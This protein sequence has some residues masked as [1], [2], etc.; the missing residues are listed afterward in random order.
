MLGTAISPPAFVPGST[1]IDGAP[2]P[3]P[4]AVE[5]DDFGGCVAPM[6]P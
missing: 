3:M 5:S 2:P 4:V 6:A 1:A